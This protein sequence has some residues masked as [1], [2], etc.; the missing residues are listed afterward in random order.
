MD[1][2]V[3]AVLVVGGDHVETAGMVADAGRPDAAI[4]ARAGQ[5]QLR[6]PIENIAD[7]APVGEIPAVPDRHPRKP[8]EGAGDEVDVLAHD[9][10]GRIGM[11]ARDDGIA[12][13][14]G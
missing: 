5:R 1:E 11:E 3:A 9:A 4:D 2:E 8:G 14:P 10:H 12:H 6:W 7:Q 13:D